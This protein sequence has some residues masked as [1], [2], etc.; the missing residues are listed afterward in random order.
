MKVTSYSNKAP[1]PKPLYF[2]GYSI[3]TSPHIS[4]GET[5]RH[6]M[7]TV[8]LTLLPVMA[9]S[10][11][12]YGINAFL[13]LST[14]IL[15]SVFTE[16]FFNL[17]KNE[18]STIPDG[19]AILTGALLALTLPPHFPIGPAAVGSV[20][21]IS[22]GKYIFGGLGYNIFNPALLGRAFL[23]ASYP[24]QI[25]TY[26]LPTPGIFYGADAVTSATVLSRLKFENFETPFPELLRGITSGSMGEGFSLLILAGGLYLVFKGYA[27]WRVP[28]SI[29]A[30]VTLLSSIANLMEPDKFAG[31]LFQLFS[32]G[33]LLGTFYMATDMVTSPVTSRGLFIYGSGIGIITVIIRYFGGLPEGIMYSILIMN[34]LTPL[35]NKYIRHKYFGETVK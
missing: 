1:K 13:L 2:T 14:C 20:F 3:S 34:S 19:S 6:I 22:I 15:A 28:L 30:S 23:Q 9:A 12:N 17:A 7:W 32:G 25:T 26:H 29:F 24:V 4:S 27:D 5:V 18:K 31:P 35:I 33:M 11:Y 16:I 21:T 10:V 8:N